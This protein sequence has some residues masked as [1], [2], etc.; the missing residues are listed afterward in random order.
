[1]ARST[2]PFSQQVP[3]GTTPAA[4]QGLVSRTIALTIALVALVN[5]TSAATYQPVSYPATAV[6]ENRLFVYGGL[7]NLSSPTSYTS[8]FLTL[9]LDDD[10][11]TDK[12][13]WEFHTEGSSSYSSMATAMA[14]GSPSKDYNRFIVTGNRN[15]IGRSPATVY[16]TDSHTWSPAADLPEVAGNATTRMQDYRRDSPGVALD[17]KSGMLIEFGGRNATAITNEIS[18]LNTTKPSDQMT[19]S[20]SG[21]LNAVPALYAP[22]LTYLPWQNATLIMGGCDHMGADEIPTQCASFDTVYTLSSDSVLSATPQATQISLRGTVFPPPRVFTCTFLRNNNIYM[23]GG[24]EP[25]TMKPLADVWILSTKN[26]TWTQTTMSNSPSKGIMGHSCLI[27]NYDQV[28]VVG[29]H[30]TDGFLQRPLSVIKLRDM[31]WSGNYYAPGVSIGAKVGLGV[32]I[33]VVL[34]AIA[35]GLLLRRRRARAA[36]ANALKRQASVDRPENNTGRRRRVKR[37]Q[38][39]RSGGDVL[40]QH[41]DH[42][43][44]HHQHYSSEPSSPIFL[45][46]SHNSNNGIPLEPLADH[47]RTLRSG[48]EWPLP[49]GPGD[50]ASHSFGVD[51]ITSHS[52]STRSMNGSTSSTVVEPTSPRFEGRQQQPGAVVDTVPPTRS[53]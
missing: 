27:A 29:G 8:Q 50:H 34:G 49:S 2:H 17:T 40:P 52:H 45:H 39:S 7:T 24:G 22:I 42:H 41:N 46:Q 48:T 13:P 25:L 26:W 32:S 31:S 14:S 30:D 19:W 44:Q 47:E 37:S 11:D 35:A 3:A 16:D 33:V 21:Y 10:F 18:I 6:L 4:H 53:S 20:Y 36:A 5:P 38:S 12:T 28:V 23:V 9:Q 51:K 15:N 43:H 1:M